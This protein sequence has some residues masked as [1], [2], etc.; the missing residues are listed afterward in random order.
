MKGWG[1]RTAALAALSALC[2]PGCDWVH[3]R[4]R[5][6][7]HLA[8]ELVNSEQSI[9]P[10][11]V[12]AESERESDELLLASGAARRLSLCVERGDAKRFRVVRGGETLANANCV[13]SRDRHDYE[14][15]VARV[16][17][18][19]RGLVCENW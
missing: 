13:V 10:V 6:C 19:A 9:G 17:W 2:A 7:G 5:S 8:V 11:Q 1:R 15:T 4:F 14:S 18:D 16:V 3:D 12:L